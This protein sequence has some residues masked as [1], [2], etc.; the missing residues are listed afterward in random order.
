MISDAEI[1]VI[2]MICCLS[3]FLEG[4]FIRAGWS[5]R[6]ERQLEGKNKNQEETIVG[7]TG[8]IEKLKAENKRWQECR[9][10]GG[11]PPDTKK[12]STVA[13]A[14]YIQCM[15]AGLLTPENIKKMAVK[16]LG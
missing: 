3:G 10:Y 15:A 5:R 13:P 1:V 14:T 6:K 11:T 7:L 16:I 12:I 2:V 9:F 8:L 4:W